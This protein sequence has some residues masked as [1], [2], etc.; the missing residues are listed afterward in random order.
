[1][2][3]STVEGRYWVELIDQ[4]TADWESFRMNHAVAKYFAK[5]IT[6][7][8]AIPRGDFADVR[9]FSLRDRNAEPVST[10]MIQPKRIDVGVAYAN[11]SPFPNFMED[12][13]ILARH[14]RVAFDT[15]CYPYGR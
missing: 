11:R 14:L 12:Y 15:R 3:L 2:F 5:H 4:A 7:R 10:A 9:F 13:S 8:R 6:D 1:M